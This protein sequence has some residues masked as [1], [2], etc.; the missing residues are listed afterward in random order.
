M[1]LDEAVAK[2]IELRDERD[3][4]KKRHSRELEAIT[5]K[6]DRIQ[7]AILKLFQRTG[8]KSARTTAGTPYIQTRVSASVADRDAFL[9]FV[10]DNDAFEFLENRVSKTAVQQYMEERE[11]TPPGVKVTTMQVINITRGK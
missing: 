2:F 11:E 4:L 1:K 9:Q 8:Q 10:R 3:A 6:M 7:N 5:D